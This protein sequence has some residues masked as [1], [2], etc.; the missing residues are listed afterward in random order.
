M[1][2][3]NRTNLQSAD[4]QQIAHDLMNMVDMEQLGAWNKKS[5]GS[6]QRNGDS[7]ADDNDEGTVVS[8]QTNLHTGSQE[9][10]DA[11]DLANEGGAVNLSADEA[12]VQ[13]TV[14]AENFD[15]APSASADGQTSDAQPDIGDWFL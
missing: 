5:N 4:D 11:G 13:F 7:E 9:R 14:N 12:P 6:L 10:V 8:N 1:A 2:P 15:S 3:P